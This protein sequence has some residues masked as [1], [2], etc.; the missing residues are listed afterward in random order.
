MLLAEIAATSEAVAAT[1]A[2]L[3]KTD[4]LAAC[5]RRLAPDEVGVAV[6]FLAG[7][8]RQRQ[9]GVGW[10][11]LREVPAPAAEASLTVLGTEVRRAFM[12]GGVL[13]QVAEAALHGATSRGR[14]GG[15]D[16]LRAVRLVL[17]RPLR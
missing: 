17:G 5:L 11:S 12:L 2:R 4:A 13:G 3:A 1:R 10:A 16:A 15:V 8:L 14:Q 6:P 9:I 7:E